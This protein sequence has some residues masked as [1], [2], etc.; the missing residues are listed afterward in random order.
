MADETREIQI[1]EKQSLEREATRPGVTFRP[2]VDI[3]ERA[4]AY[5][6]RADLPGVDENQV[7]VKLEEGVLS[8]DATLAVEPDP[9][10][11]L[12]HGEYRLGG[13]HREFA[14]SDQIDAEG[15]TA[16]M[17]DGV[18]ELVLPKSEAARPRQI[19]V[20]SA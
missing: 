15:I 16:R 17:R 11:T 3:V 1:R 19:P 5:W 9:S 6:V 18:L 7:R 8:I 12:L 13:F 14:V 10:W 4:D 20:K 2:D